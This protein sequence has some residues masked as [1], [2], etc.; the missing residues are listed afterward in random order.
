MKVKTKRSNFTCVPN[1]TLRDKRLTL[2]AR[3]LLAF[4]L[5]LP[6]TWEY[7]VEGLARATGEGRDS[8]KSALKELEAGG[9]LIRQQARNEQGKLAGME[10][11]LFDISQP[12]QEDEAPKPAEP[13]TE[14][15]LAGKPST[16]EPLAEKPIQINKDIYNK[17]LIKKERERDNN[18]RTKITPVLTT[19][20]SGLQEQGF[21][22]FWEAYP[23]KANKPTAR[24]AWRALPVDVNLYDRIMAAVARYKQT[25]QWQDANYIPY[26]ENFLQDERWEDDIALPATGSDPWGA[27][28][29]KYGGA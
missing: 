3:G 15:P 1:E 29:K 9:Y 20:Q 16:A 7:S 13:L 21:E 19:A 27:A 23:R 10:Y 26:P 8:I 12:C 2:K 25:R 4:C 17:D 5:S 28:F 18:A 6:D 24:I 14:K 22:R 11:T